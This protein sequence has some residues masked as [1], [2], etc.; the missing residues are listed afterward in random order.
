MDRENHLFVIPA[1]MKN[2][3]M[4]DQRLAKNLTYE[5]KDDSTVPK[6]LITQ[7][8]GAEPVLHLLTR[9]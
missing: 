3:M 8:L 1:V 6:I 2:E 5:K 4:M 9:Q 7:I